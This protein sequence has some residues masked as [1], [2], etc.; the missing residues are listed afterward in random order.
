M[1]KGG[2]LLR[3]DNDQPNILPL[4]MFMSI[5]QVGGDQGRDGGYTK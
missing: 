1:P 2:K 4:D 3:Q 5:M